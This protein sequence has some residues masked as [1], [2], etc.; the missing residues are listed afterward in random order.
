VLT[1]KLYCWTETHFTFYLISND[2]KNTKFR[3]HIIF[4][5]SGVKKILF[6]VC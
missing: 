1:L 6:L 5:P 2:P 4:P 3:S